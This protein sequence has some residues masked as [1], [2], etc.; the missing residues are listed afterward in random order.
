MEISEDNG[1]ASRGIRILEGSTILYRIG[2]LVLKIFSREEPDFCRNEAQFLKLLQGR[3]SVRTPELVSTGTHDGYPYI[4]ME[5]MQGSPLKGIWNRL[6]PRGREKVTEQAG[7]MLRELHSLPTEEVTFTETRWD[8]FIEY[9]K[10]YSERNHRGFGLDENRI[11]QILQFIESSAPVENLSERV[12]CH[13]EIMREH[14]FAKRT[15]SGT[16]LAGLIDFEPSMVAVPE[17][18][19]CSVGLFLT[20]GEKGL[21]RVFSDAYGYKGSA[22]AIMRMLLL[23]RYSNMK[24]FIST[25]PPETGSGSLEQLSAYW[26]S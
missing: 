20:A 18:D 25:L 15:G 22:E 9:Q 7:W 14:L 8:D 17:Y 4:I 1:L 23:H 5:K 19:L 10:R 24:W 26:F 21:F 12:I 16:T 2:E 11:A 3:L 13:T 6:S